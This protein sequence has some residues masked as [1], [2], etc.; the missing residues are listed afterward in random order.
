MENK[1]IKLN[2]LELEPGIGCS[3]I[4]GY[5]TVDGRELEILKIRAADITNDTK[6]IV[7]SLS[8]ESLTD[9]INLFNNSLTPGT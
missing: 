1:P 4:I 3:N 2:R 6:M 7:I 8:N 5:Q 9:L